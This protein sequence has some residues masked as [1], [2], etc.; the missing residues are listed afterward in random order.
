VPTVTYNGKFYSKAGRIPGFADWRRGREVEMSQDVLNQWR[1][2]LLPLSD[3]HIEDDWGVDLGSDGI[4]D[5]GWTKAAIQTWLLGRGENVPGGYKTKTTLLGMVEG[6]LN[7]AP[8]EEA[9]VEEVVEEPV[10]EE[11]VAEDDET[12]QE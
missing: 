1:H 4:P 11:A 7:P 12:E 10:V 5:E 2:T 3:F 6:I 8:V 9:V